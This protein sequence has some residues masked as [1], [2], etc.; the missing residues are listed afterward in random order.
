MQ[1]MCYLLVYMCG[2]DAKKTPLLSHELGYNNS[3]YMRGSHKRVI[4]YHFNLKHFKNIII[5]TN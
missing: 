1:S 5:P 2:L 4:N 3:L